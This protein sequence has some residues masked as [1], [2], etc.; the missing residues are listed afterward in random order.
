MLQAFVIPLAG[1]EAFLIIAISLAYYPQKPPPGDCAVHWGIAASLVL[2]SVPRG[3]F[4]RRGIR[5]WGRGARAR[6]C[7]FRSHRS[8]FTCGVRKQSNATSKAYGAG[9]EGGGAAF[10]GVFSSL[11]ITREGMETAL[12]M[13]TLLFR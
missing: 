6:G 12:L 1:L 11:L 3:Y 7:G 8:P 2:A 9:I 4:I 5:H 10:A 13:G